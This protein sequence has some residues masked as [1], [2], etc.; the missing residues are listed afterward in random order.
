M[1]QI[2]QLW[3]EKDRVVGSA[4]G[5]HS[6]VV[7]KQLPE[8]RDVPLVDLSLGNLFFPGFPQRLG[9]WRFLS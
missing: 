8:N 3:S 6:R 9:G 2:R 5:E 1:V 4:L 7:E